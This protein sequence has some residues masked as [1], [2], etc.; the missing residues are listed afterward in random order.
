[1]KSK[2][3]KDYQKRG[4]V[5]YASVV[6]WLL[7]CGRGTKKC[8]ECELAGVGLNLTN[9]WINNGYFISDKSIVSYC[10]SNQVMTF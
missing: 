2:L 5:L 7:I 1:M 10:L 3:S 6:D 8:N 9:I 4:R